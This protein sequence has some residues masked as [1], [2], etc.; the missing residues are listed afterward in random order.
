MKTLDEM[1]L[2]EAGHSKELGSL[3]RS[4]AENGGRLDVVVVGS[5]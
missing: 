1:G 2:G 5:V 4:I 3:F